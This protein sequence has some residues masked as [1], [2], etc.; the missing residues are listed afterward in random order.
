LGTRESYVD[1]YR[2]LYESGAEGFSPFEEAL[3]G[4]GEWTR[5][6]SLPWIFVVLPEFHD[7]DGAFEDVYDLVRAKASA[8]GAIVVDATAA[9][10]GHDPASIWVAYNDVHPNARGHAIIAEAIL[11]Q[12]DPAIFRAPPADQDRS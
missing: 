2:G 8:A 12:V 4:I 11:D 5:T 1:Y 3:G 9:F 6:R 10:R 7:F